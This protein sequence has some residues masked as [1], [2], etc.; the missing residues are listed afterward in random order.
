[1][2]FNIEADTGYEI[3]GYVV[4]DNFEKTPVLEV[5]KEGQ[6]LLTFACNQ[7]RYALVTAGRHATGLCG[8][9]IT[10]EMIDDLSSHNSLEI[11]DVDTGLLIYRRRD[12]STVLQRRLLRLETHLFPLWDLDDAVGSRFQIFHKGIE[13]LGRETTTQAFHLDNIPSLYISGRIAIRPY[14]NLITDRFASIFI[15]SDPYYELAERL[16]ILKNVGTV[17]NYY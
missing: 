8:F 14:E 5:K 7:Q 1:M 2:L 4:P 15:M 16:Y 11:F 10:H 9:S 3:I 13:R 6:T 17:E 12:P